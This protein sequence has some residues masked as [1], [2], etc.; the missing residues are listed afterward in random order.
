MYFSSMNIHRISKT[1]L[2]SIIL[3]L[4]FVIHVQAEFIEKQKLT[5]SDAGSEDF[6]GQN[7]SISGDR[8]VVGAFGDD[9]NGPSSGAAYV[10]ERQSN[11]SWLEVAKLTASDGAAGDLF[12]DSVSISGDRLVVGAF[13]ADVNTVNVGAAYV[14]ERQGNGN[15][16]EVAKLTASDGTISDFFGASVSLS[17]GRLVTGAFGDDV[18]GVSSGSV[19]V[20][21]R[22]GNGSWQE[23]AKLT[24]S[25][26]QARELFGSNVSL[27]GDRFVASAVQNN[28]NAMFSGS[29]YVFERQSGGRW[30]EVAKLTASDNETNDRFA[31]SLSI[32]GDR[33]VV[34]A[35]LDDDLGRG[36][37]S[38]Y[39][40]ERQSDG[41]WQEVTKLLASDGTTF[42]FFGENVS[43]SND[44]IAVGAGFDDDLGS[45]SGSA[46][47]FERQSDGS[48]QEVV[49]LTASDGT[50]EDFFGIGVSLSGDRLLVGAFRDDDKGLA[51]GSAYVFESS[52]ILP[53]LPCNCANATIAGTDGNDLLIGTPG[54]DVICGFG[55]DDRLFGGGGNDCLI[56]GSGNDRLFGESGD[57]DLRGGT[58][59]DQLRGGSGNDELRGEAGNDNLRGGADDDELQGSTGDDILRG[60]DGNDVL[61]GNAGNDV[62][63]GGRGNDDL[64]GGSDDDIIK[65]DDGGDALHGDG[66]NDDLRGGRGNDDLRGGSGEDDVR[67]GLG[68]DIIRGDGGN[69]TLR[70]NGGD[71]T[72]RGGAE[73][74]DLNGGSGNDSLNGGSGID[75]CNG[76]SGVDTAGNCENITG[77]P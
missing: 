27:S 2:I 7:V 21:E 55:G 3:S 63:R 8:L 17:G 60:D 34:G 76:G 65:G 46:Y 42:D 18:N 29:A 36:S 62:L 5:A 30:Q 19:Y 53:S 77:V 64:R 44:R 41:S 56:G 28:D 14:F 31:S 1:I 74:D 13:R 51:A 58:G 72:L 33:L 66:G 15:W 61:Q 25:D 32:S 37:G 35:R 67:G 12:G 45:A 23:V 59:D 11:G 71:D 43:V 54:N 73:A 24:A 39:V 40:F 22:Q 50:S 52:L 49:K 57:D 48:W 47:V 70:G 38:A 9:D 69:D 26:G 75:I 16:L 20:F 10:F 4:M 6:F 68:N